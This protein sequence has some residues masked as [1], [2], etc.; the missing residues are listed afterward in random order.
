MRDKCL[1]PIGVFDSGVGGLTILRSLKKFLSHESFIYICDTAR[2]P[3]GI[4]SKNI[5]HYYTI[6]SVNFLIKQKIKALVIACNTASSVSLSYL[7]NKYS[8]LFPVIGVIDPILKKII[9]VIKDNRVIILATRTTIDSKLY[10]R[11]IRKNC[12]HAIILSKSC[13]VLVTLA[14]EGMI[15]NSIVREVFKYYLGNINQN[16]IILLGCTHFNVFKS[17]LKKNLPKRIKIIDSSISTAF[18]LYKVFKKNNLFNFDY[19]FKSKIYYFVTDSIKRFQKVGKFFL[20]EV[21]EEDNVKQI[22]I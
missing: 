19:T 14:E 18:A 10:Q 22:K 11:Y 4:K 5:V 7:K 16:D 3:Y 20:G 13:N 15:D 1:L 17:L 21:I 8:H 2:F 9:S 12:P 6:R